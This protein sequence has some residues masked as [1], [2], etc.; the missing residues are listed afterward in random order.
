[1][2]DQ[3]V[4]LKESVKVPLAK[5]YSCHICRWINEEI[6]RCAS[7]GHRLCID[8]EWL[9]PKIGRAHV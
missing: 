9:M 8:C 1:M 2:I 4:L 7:C 5:R 6:E 3:Q